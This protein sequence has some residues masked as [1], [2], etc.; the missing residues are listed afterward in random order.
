LVRII[1]KLLEQ[2]VRRWDSK[3]KF[4]LWANRVTCKKSIGTSPFK[5][6][7]GTEAIFPIQLALP[8]AK[9]LQESDEEPNDL[10]RRI[11]DLVQLQQDRDQLLGKAQLHQEM[12]KRNFDKKVKSNVFKTG[13]MVLK[14]DAARQEKGKHGKFD[15][16]WTSPF[17]ITEVQQNNTFVLQSLFRRASFRRHFQRALLEDLFFIML[18]EKPG[19]FVHISFQFCF[20][21]FVI[22]ITPCPM[23][24][25]L[26]FRFQ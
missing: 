6:V 2:N 8:V 16:L 4:A 11:H 14:W 19:S 7:Y 1:Q 13:D 12:I 10:T 22:Q 5:L 23:E 24:L 17:I 21:Y 26:V 18:L 15:A 9:F 3:L 20:L 25:E